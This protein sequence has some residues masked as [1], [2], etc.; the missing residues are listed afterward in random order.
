M[1][2]QHHRARNIWANWRL[3][4]E[5]LNNKQKIEVKSMRS[6]VFKLFVTTLFMGVAFLV[7][8][9]DSDNKSGS[10]AA[11]FLKI[12]VGARAMALGGAIVASTDDAFSLYWNP[13]ALTKVSHVTVAGVYTN[14]FADIDHQFLGLV[15]PVNQSSVVG[16]QAT[17]LTMDEMEITTINDPHGTG[18]FFEARDLAIGVSYAVRLTNYFSVGITGKYIQQEIYNEIAS[19]FAFD[20]GSVLDVPFRGLKLG[21]RFSNFGGKLQLDGRDLTREYDLNP[22]NTLN[23]GVEARLKTEPWELP[24]VFQVGISGDLVGKSDAFVVSETNRLTLSIDGSHPTDS[25]EFASFG[26]EY[27]YNDLIALRTGYRLNRDVEKLFY[28]IGLQ[29][30]LASTSKFNFDYAIA[31]FDELDYVHIFSSSLSF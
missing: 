17:L 19:T 5:Q 21:M 18:E 26:V 16:F 22:D 13:S 1:W 8:A 6:F 25:P 24:V 2:Y 20:F 31:S 30:P 14:W 9:Q 12:G 23:V 28:G 3:S 15:I 7:Q 11:Q 27:M 10:A 29:L 4:D